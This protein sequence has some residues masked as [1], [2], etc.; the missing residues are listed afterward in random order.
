[1]ATHHHRHIDAGQRA[2]VEVEPHEGLRDE[3]G[4]RR[5]SRHVVGAHQVVVDRLGDMHAAQIVARLLRFLGDDAH[6]IGA[7]VAPDVEEVAN[8]VRP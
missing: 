8:V 2:I 4:R 3:P 6:R 1:M 5:I 7:V